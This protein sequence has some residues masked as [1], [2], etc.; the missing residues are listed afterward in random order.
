[1]Y[2]INIVFIVIYVLELLIK[3]AAYL[4]L[5]FFDAWNLFDLLVVMSS[6]VELAMVGSGGG[7]GLS[8]LRTLRLLKVSCTRPAYVSALMQECYVSASLQACSV[9]AS[10]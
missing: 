9:S 1:M 7:A 10:L 2:A 4:H 3:F 5:F 6:V 8:S